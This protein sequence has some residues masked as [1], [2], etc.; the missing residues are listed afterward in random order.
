MELQQDGPILLKSGFQQFHGKPV[1]PHCFLVCHCFHRC[2]NL[3]LRGLDPDGTH[4]WL[5]RQPLPYAG[6]EH[7]GLRVRNE[8][9]N[10]THLSRIHPLSRSSLPPSSRT[11]CESTFFVLLQ[12]HRFDVL[13]ESMLIS[14][15]Q[16]L[17]Q[18]NDVALEKNERLLYVALSSASY[19]LSWRPSAAAHLWCLFSG[20]ATP[21]ASHQSQSAAQLPF[22]RLHSN[23]V[24]ASFVPGEGSPIQRSA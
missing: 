1:R 12:L 24:L 21:R 13:E 11:H 14:H 2:G 8:R 20:A 15:T 10:R 23:L 7:V 6:I 18:L 9:K 17:L 16:L 3:L 19:M 22:G 4:D 5:L